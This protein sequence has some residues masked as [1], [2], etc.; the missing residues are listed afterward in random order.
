MNASSPAVKDSEASITSPFRYSNAA[1]SM[2]KHLHPPAREVLCQ[3]RFGFGPLSLLG[4]FCTGGGGSWT[5]S[6]REV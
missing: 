6:R 5:F 3:R 2:Q 4:Q 1:D